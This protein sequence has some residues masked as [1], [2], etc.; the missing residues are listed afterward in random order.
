MKITKSL[1]AAL[2]LAM[3][4]VPLVACGS[5]SNT[6]QE[7]HPS[8][9]K[10][11]YYE[12]PSSGQAKGWLKAADIF[13]K[14][15]G[16]KVDFEVKSF[17]QIAQ[18]GSQFLN[19]DEAPDV[20]ESNRGNGSAG[21]LSSEK[22][23]TDLK[24][25]VEKYGWDRKVKGQ[26]AAVGKYDDRGVMDGDTWY[27]ISSY[28][29]MQRVYYNKNLFD[30][31]GIAIPTSF[32]EFTAALQKFKDN[33]VTPIAADAQEY[34]VLWLWWQLAMTKADTAF[35][36]DWQLYKHK[37]DWNSEPLTFATNT[38]KD[39]VDKGYISR[40]ATGM[41]AEDT[42]T[43]FIKGDYPIY[44]TG[45]WNQSRFMDQIKGF[46]WTAAI[47]PDA[48][49]VEGCAG[50][51]LVIPEKSK[52]KDLAA[53]YIDVVLSKEVQ[54]YIGN[55]G[56]VPVAADTKA[57]T[58]PKSRDLVDE[59]TKAAAANRMSY[60]PDYPAPNLTDAMPAALQGLV[61]GTKDPAQVLKTI[62]KN[63]DD[64]VSQLGLN[65]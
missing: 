12:E 59:Y 26:A 38:I 55:E 24:P 50:N 53:Q 18:N 29:E 2:A 15:T 45:T 10:I 42:T 41:K 54:N 56:G 17:T 65:D 48:R 33:G 32:D 23:L 7:E 30:K 60:Y 11:W 62:H 52:R 20:M 14:K 63:Y 58:N 61:N 6:A 44:Q 21:V 37:V 22:L 57:I 51:L 16:V 8:S 13:T 1:G 25:Y 46:D 36:D 43:A 34:G 28:A 64:G 3:S 47:F 35:I 19:S 27:G 4:V 31:Y 40:N 39:W 49:K 9:I 5:N